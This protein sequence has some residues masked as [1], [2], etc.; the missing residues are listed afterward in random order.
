LLT[1]GGGEPTNHPAAGALSNPRGH[2]TKAKGEKG[3][4]MKSK[5]LKKGMNAKAKRKEQVQ[6]LEVH[7]S[8]IA[9]CPEKAGVSV[10]Y[11]R[12]LRGVSRGEWL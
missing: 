10:F 1:G 4:R 7:L 2:P 11:R 9:R 5:Q 6:H 12:V 3:V 8:N